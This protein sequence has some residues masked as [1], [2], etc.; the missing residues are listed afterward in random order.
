MTKFADTAAAAAFI[1]SADDR[2]TSVKI[3]E[4]LVFFARN[5]DEAESLWNGDG[6]GKI[7]H[8]SDIVE[9]VTDNGLTDASEYYWGMAS[10]E[11]AQDA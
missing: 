1:A 7:A 9:R 11:W 8:M 2:Q 4:A 3:M 10:N 5:E 6:I